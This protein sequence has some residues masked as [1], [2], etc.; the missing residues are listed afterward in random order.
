MVLAAVVAWYAG[1]HLKITPTRSL[2]HRVFWA[3]ASRASINHVRKGSFV[4]FKT[5]SPAPLNRVAREIKRVGCT[6]GEVLTVDAHDN[7]YCSGEYL[8]R[9]KRNTLLGEPLA[10]FRFAGKVPEGMLF[11]IGDH[12]DSYDSRYY[13]FV[14]HERI[15]EVAWALF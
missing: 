8:G 12:R 7:Y 15:L 14:A 5:Y 4:I 10:P 13:G 3:S 9:A 11:V 1:D 6:P 2:T